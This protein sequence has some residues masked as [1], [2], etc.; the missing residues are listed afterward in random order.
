MGIPCKDPLEEEKKRE[1][2]R[3]GGESGRNKTINEEKR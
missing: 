3:Q 1:T 2:Q